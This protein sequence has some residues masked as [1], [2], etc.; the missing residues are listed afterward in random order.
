[1]PFLL[2]LHFKICRCFPWLPLPGR[3]SSCSK[4]LFDLSHHHWPFLPTPFQ[5]FPAEVLKPPA[6]FR[7]GLNAIALPRGGSLSHM[8][9][10]QQSNPLGCQS[11]T[12]RKAHLGLATPLLPSFPGGLGCH[13]LSR[14]SPA[15]GDA[16]PS[17][18]LLHPCWSVPEEAWGG[19]CS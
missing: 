13:Q 3:G 6:L 17:L 2:M 19:S 18:W 16:L 8:D 4:G 15:F 5:K 12:N 7:A 11:H 14:L 10:P 9:P 1:M